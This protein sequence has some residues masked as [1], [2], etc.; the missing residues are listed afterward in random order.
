MGKLD[1]TNVYWSIR[2]LAQWR[3]ILVVREGGKGGDTRAFL[4]VGSTS[5]Q[6]LAVSQ[7]FGALCNARHACFD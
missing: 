5:P 1:L 7:G 3:R 4:L 6:Y 2:L